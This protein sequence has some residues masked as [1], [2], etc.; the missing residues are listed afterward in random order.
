[1]QGRIG[2]AS[3]QAFA[4]SRM[5]FNHPDAAAQFLVDVQRHEQTPALRENSHGWKGRKRLLVPHRM[6]HTL[7]S[8]LQDCFSIIVRERRHPAASSAIPACAVCGAA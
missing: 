1:M 5:A 4:Y 6:E 2:R 8:Q 7:A 3:R